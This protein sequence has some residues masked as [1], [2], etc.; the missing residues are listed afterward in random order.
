MKT[1]ATNRN[2]LFYGKYKYKVSIDIVG[3]RH[4]SYSGNYDEFA[5]RLSNKGYAIEV[6]YEGSKYRKLFDFYK[7]YMDNKEV[8]F[9]RDFSFLGFYT[10]NEDILNELMV[11]NLGLK[12]YE[13]VP[14]PAKVMYFAKE[15]QYKYRMYLKATRVSEPLIDSISGFCD[16]YKDKDINISNGLIQF[17]D[18][19]HWKKRFYS[20]L[21]NNF[22]IEFNDDSMIT[23]M[24]L[25]MSECIGK[26][27]RLE[28]RPES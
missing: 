10:S 14:P 22:F 7:K 9:L 18:S 26:T 1:I 11:L 15:P 4:L 27:Y 12:V 25:M 6:N 8:T 19:K 21:N 23:I 17:I 3:S 2:R 20:Y 28:K 13:A 5:K 16:T 24:H